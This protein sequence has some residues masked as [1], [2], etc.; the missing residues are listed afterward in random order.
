MQLQAVRTAS[1]ITKEEKAPELITQQTEDGGSTFDS[2]SPSLF[3]IALKLHT[4]RQL[5]DGANYEIRMAY[6]SCN[7]LRI[8]ANIQ[9]GN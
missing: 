1:E 4:L 7:I 9:Q 2:Y 6:G 3:C 5:A 8:Y